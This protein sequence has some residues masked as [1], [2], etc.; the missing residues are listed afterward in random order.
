MFFRWRPGRFIQLCTVWRSRGWL[1]SEW[2]M[3]QNNQRAKFYK[4]TARGRKQLT[5]E[6]S[7]WDQ[8][9]RAIGGVMNPVEEA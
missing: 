2:G 1:A 6:Q 7:R 8:L 9:V 4:L 5:A 3:S